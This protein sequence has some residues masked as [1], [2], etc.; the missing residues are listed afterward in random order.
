MQAF[1]IKLSF[2]QH[3]LYT[4]IV[5][6]ADSCLL[7]NKFVFIAED[8]DLLPQKAFILIPNHK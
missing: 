3:L 7:M 5:A 8:D 2:T 1:Y 4:K 6:S